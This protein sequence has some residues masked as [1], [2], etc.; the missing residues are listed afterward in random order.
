MENMCTFFSGRSYCN[1]SKWYLCIVFWISFY[2]SYPPYFI[3][4][5]SWNTW[6][7]FAH[8]SIFFIP[9]RRSSNYQYN[10]MN[11]T[12]N[13]RMEKECGYTESKTSIFNHFFCFLNSQIILFIDLKR[14]LGKICCFS[15]PASQLAK[16]TNKLK[17]YFCIADLLKLVHNKKNVCYLLHEPSLFSFV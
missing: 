2:K 1:I 7:K 16:Q 15:M 3:Q 17:A 9:G 8:Y 4:F 6:G 13:Q 14:H 5:P 12:T 10:V 11:T